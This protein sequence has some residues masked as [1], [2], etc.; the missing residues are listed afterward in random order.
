MSDN[1]TLSFDDVKSSEIDIFGNKF[2]VNFSEEYIERLKAL[3]V[4]NIEDKDVFAQLKTML[5]LILSDE[6][7][8]DSIS[9]AY[10]SHTN[11]EF[12]TQVFIK[13]MAFIFNEY[14][15]EIA[16]IKGTDFGAKNL[17]REQRR[18]DKPYQNKSYNNYRRY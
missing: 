17:N 16:S 11:K 1:R 6:K 3:K 10:K 8:Y 5:N 14:N 9:N 15:K 4:E 13:V 12:G 2:E 18:Y 7:A